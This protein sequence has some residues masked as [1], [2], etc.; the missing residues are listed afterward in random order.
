MSNPLSMKSWSPYAV[1]I[2]IGMLSWF[3]FAT[4]DTPL[5]ITTAFEHSAAL[6]KKAVAP[7]AAESNSYFSEKGQ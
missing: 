1:G 2:A 4:A 7:S 3:S 6:T 5:G